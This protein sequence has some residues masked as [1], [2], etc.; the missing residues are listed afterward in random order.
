M[1]QNEYDKND[2]LSVTT[3]ANLGIQHTDVCLNPCFSY[4]G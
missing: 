1:G 2:I 4:R 3:P